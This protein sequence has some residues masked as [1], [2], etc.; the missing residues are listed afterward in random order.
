[1]DPE[2]DDYADLDPVRPRRSWYGSVGYLAV[3][4]ALAGGT[5]SAA[6]FA[7]GD[8]S[9]AG[10]WVLGI[11][12]IVGPYALVLL[13]ARRAGAGGRGRGVIQA[14]GPMV[15][16]AGSLLLATALGDVQSR[17]RRGRPPEIPG[18]VLVGGPLLFVEWASGALA[19]L[20]ARPARSTG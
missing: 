9:P 12:S 18:L 20:V 13:A 14:C 2:R 11:V 17:T 15:L 1:M 3:A 8:Q 4:A 6:A 7:F 16:V 5:L 19:L 10:T